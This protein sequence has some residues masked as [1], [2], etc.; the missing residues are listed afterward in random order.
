M[1]KAEIEREL[2][3]TLIARAWPRADS[4]R[5]IWSRCGWIEIDGCVFASHKSGH[6]LLLLSPSP[7][8]VGEIS[9]KIKRKRNE[10]KER[11][12]EE[13][14]KELYELCVTLHG[15]Q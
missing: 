1:L 14:E 2:N 3:F 11:D 9:D 4:V 15:S 7:S 13:R 8:S 5:S 6:K 10:E 12:G